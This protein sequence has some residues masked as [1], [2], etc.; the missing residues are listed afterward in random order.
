MFYLYRK[1]SSSKEKVRSY[2]KNNRIYTF[3]ARSIGI[4]KMAVINRQ[5]Q[6]VF[7]QLE[8]RIR[9]FSSRINGFFYI[10]NDPENFLFQNIDP[11]RIG[12]IF[13]TITRILVIFSLYQSKKGTG[14]HIFD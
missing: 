10:V 9:L 5:T 1:T 2:Q 13:L 8:W 11:V 14:P 7:F 3:S 12:C 4:K 6:L